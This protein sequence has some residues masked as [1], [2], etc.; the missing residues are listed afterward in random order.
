MLP[1]FLRKK[2]INKNLIGTIR[3]EFISDSFAL[4]DVYFQQSSQVCGGRSE[5]EPFCTGRLQEVLCALGP[6]P[7]NSVD[8]Q[9]MKKTEQGVHYVYVWLFFSS[10]QQT[11][12]QEPKIQYVPLKATAA[13]D[14][15]LTKPQD[16]LK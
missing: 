9:H 8:P 6:L 10:I 12:W 3:R 11:R 2:N 14:F 15:E 1:C 16:C 13:P 5:D 4:V 7:V